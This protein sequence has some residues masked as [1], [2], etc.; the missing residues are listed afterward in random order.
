MLK[1]DLNVGLIC[2]DHI[3]VSFYRKVNLFQKLVMLFEINC[4]IYIFMILL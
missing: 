3:N 4:I 1:D 2:Y